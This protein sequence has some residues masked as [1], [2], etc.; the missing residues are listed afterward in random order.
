VTKAKGKVAAAVAPLP[1]PDDL[2]V[3][4]LRSHLANLNRVATLRKARED[5]L[6]FC[7]LM[8]PDIEAPEDFTRSGFEVAKHHA[9][10]GKALQGVESGRY[11]RLIVTLPP[12]HG[13]TQMISKF[14]GIWSL[15]RD[16]YQQIAFGTYGG[17][18]AEDIGK[19]VRELLQSQRY[20]DIF[21]Q[22]QLRSDAKAAG[23]LKLTNGGAFRFVGRGG[24]LTGKGAHVLIIDDILKD[25][26]EADSPTIREKSW[27]WFTKV[28]MTRLMKVGAKVI[29]VMTRW[30]EDDLVG[31]LTNP[32]N[33]AY[34]RDIAKEWSIL[35]LP[36]EAEIND[37]LGRQPGEALWPE[38]FPVPFLQSQKR[39]DPL[40]YAALYQQR[41]SPEE[42]AFFKNDEIM[43]YAMHERPKLETMRF[44]VASDH[45]VGADKKKHDASVFI[46]GG[47]CPKNMLWLVDC[48]W[49]RAPADVAVEAMLDLMDTWRPILWWAEDGHITKSIGPFLLKRKLE[50]GIGGCAIDTVH[51]AKSKEQRAQSIKGLMGLR[52]VMFP[53]AA[54][55]FSQAK[56]ELLQFPNGANDDF[57]DALSLMGLRMLQIIGKTQYQDVTAPGE[58]TWAWWKKEIAHQEKM[59]NGGNERL[60]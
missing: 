30:H 50:R 53:K 5:F 14:F 51:P 33:P 60:Y 27:H 59:R 38:R 46:V 7:R 25:A 56:H 44:Y 34:D 10:I 39:L 31:R 40:G 41:P 12:R 11:P 58:G 48:W 43:T 47:V 6:L 16:P 42:G 2:S 45:A 28:A 23:S 57:V 24:P 20:K 32:Q 54:P 15:G 19:D 37:P 17:E 26:E 21:P 18:Y 8:M 55:W 35:N 49:K 29:I 36:A 4:E 13:K 52:R 3:E 9:A 22:I 1:D